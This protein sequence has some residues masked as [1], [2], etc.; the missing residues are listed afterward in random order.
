MSRG[1]PEIKAVFTALE[2]RS[3]PDRDAYLAASCGGDA[4]FRRRIE[5]LLAAHDRAGDVLGPDG[6]SVEV[7]GSRAGTATAT[8]AFEPAVRNDTE[9]MRSWPRAGAIEP[10]VDHDLNAAADGD[11]LPPGAAVRYFGDYEIRREL[12]RGGMGVVYEARQISLNRRVALKMVKAGL[13]AGDDELRRFRN[14]AE[15]AALL[16]HPGLVPLYEVGCHDGQHYLCMKLVPG[17]SLVPLIGRYL[18]DPRAAAQLVAEAADAVAHA[19]ARGILH[20]DLK[21]ANILVDNQGRPHVTDFGL[22]KRVEGDVELTQS[23]AI[24][25]TPAYM[26]PEQASGRRGAVTTASDVYGLGAVLYA[27]LTG[28]A[29]F[30]GDSVVETIDA[31]R[32]QPPERPRKLNAAV[33]PDLETICLKCL[34]KDPRR[35]YPSAQALAD[36]LTGWLE[37]RPI[38]A[39]RVGTVERAWLWCKRRPAV[40]GLSAAT[41]LVALAGLSFGVWQWSAAL[42]NARIAKANAEMALR[43]AKEAKLSTRVACDTVDD[44][45]TYIAAVNLTDIPQLARMASV[46]TLLLDKART[47]YE[48]LRDENDHRDDP[49]L[50]W[51][52][53]RAQGR[54]GDIQAMLSRF[55]DAEASYRD[56]IGRLESLAAEHPAGAQLGRDAASGALGWDILRD[57]ARIRI[58]LAILLKDLYRLDEARDQFRKAVASG[59]E[60]ETSGDGSEGDLLAEIDYQGGFLPARSDGDLLAEID[61]QGARL[62]A[63]DAELGGSLDSA[64]SPESRATTEAYLR[65]IF[66]QEERVAKALIRDEA[67]RHLLEQRARL[68]RFRN[69]LGRLLAAESRFDQAE[70]EFRRVLDLIPKSDRSPGAR[71][72]RARGVNN[73]GVLLLQRAAAATESERKALI[74]QAVAFI[75]TAIDL[76]EGLGQEFPEVP[77]YREELVD[78]YANLAQI[79]QSSKDHARAMDDLRRAEALSG[80]LDRVSPTMPRYRVQAARLC[81]LMAMAHLLQKKTGP[82]EEYARKSIERLTSLEPIYHGMPG[83]LRA[84]LGRGYL[85]LAQVLAEKKEIDAAREAAERAAHHHQAALNASPGSPRYRQY[86]WDNHVFLALVRLRLG[87]LEGAARDAE[88]LPRVRP[89][90]ASSYLQSAGLL[91]QCARK[92]SRGHEARF[93]D[94]AVAVLRAGVERR[95]LDPSRLKQ[96]VL[97]PLRDREDFRHLLQVPT[98]AAGG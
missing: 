38:M 14:E 73:L 58:G 6:Q 76:L 70:H 97:D 93:Y 66:R 33:P 28:R 31:V 53:A 96:P 80:E 86:L 64:D 2:R 55:G 71:W 79:E 49:E 39:R 98:S 43:S 69:N 15:A 68:G 40:A 94:R 82:A 50:R 92:A 10:M 59:R 77:P 63:R 22:A 62:L 56:A 45:M 89:D 16:D 13:L 18:D 21:P 23:G 30:G 5:D 20:R 11:G 9:A 44:L 37:S 12:G 65:A 83:Y 67:G 7:A 17:G 41:L 90:H 78:A 4:D 32:N 42:R 52:S 88:E 26:S 29:P 46:R 48:R 81:Q 3:G 75:R 25:G 85:R 35:R 8:D 61:I 51:V 87:D 1:K 60:L 91:I 95:R 74:A 36:D 19:H 34:E 84:S 47:A 57:L 72:Q 24:L 27:L 54:L